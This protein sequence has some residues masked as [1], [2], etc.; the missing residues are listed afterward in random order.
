MKATWLFPSMLL[1]MLGACN[2]KPK[3]QVVVDDPGSATTATITAKNTNMKGFKANIEKDA[4]ANTYYRKVLYTGPHMQLVLMSLKP[5]EEIGEETHLKSDQFFRFESGTGKC[6]V[7]ETV[8]EVQ[9]GDVVLV[10]WGAKHNVI[11]TDARNDLKLYT[12]CATP[13]HKDGI[14]RATKEEAEKNEAKFDGKTTE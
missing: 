5:G 14:V 7:N 9:A 8:Y 2:S 11:N 10:P 13:N 1:L 4:L 3:E 6:I 12:I